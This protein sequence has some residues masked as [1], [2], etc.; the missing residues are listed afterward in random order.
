MSRFHVVGYKRIVFMKRIVIYLFLIYV[1]K[2]ELVTHK[3]QLIC[4]FFSYLFSNHF[5]IITDQDS[6]YTG[7]EGLTCV[8][9][10]A[11][12]VVRCL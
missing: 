1:F 12:K 10:I 8:R 11:A 5:V 6:P 7:S 2:A 9:E 3:T 4:C